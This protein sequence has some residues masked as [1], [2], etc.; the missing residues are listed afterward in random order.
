MTERVLGKQFET[1]G[2]ICVI[3]KTSRGKTPKTFVSANNSK[4]RNKGED[5]V[6]DGW[7]FTYL[8]IGV[9]C[10]PNGKRERLN[11]T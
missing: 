10:L 8:V 7:R 2:G 11:L 1:L 6:A 5:R 3:C 4:K 9:G